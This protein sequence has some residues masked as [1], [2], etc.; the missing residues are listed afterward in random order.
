MV[1][2]SAHLLGPYDLQTPPCTTAQSMLLQQ[3]ANKL[4]RTFHLRKAPRSDILSLSPLL[5]PLS[6]LDLITTTCCSSC[7]PL[8]LLMYI[9]IKKS[10]PTSLQS[11][12]S[13]GW[14]GRA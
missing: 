10:R 13:G 11:S 12:R 4:C 6:E 14:S 3:Q 2:P 1:Q 9:Y 8:C 5:D 7:F